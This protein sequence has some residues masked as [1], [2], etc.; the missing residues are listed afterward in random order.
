[1]KEMDIVKRWNSFG[2]A[3]KWLNTEE[4]L[5]WVSTAKHYN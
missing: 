1:L 5:A 3:E 4:G 2:K